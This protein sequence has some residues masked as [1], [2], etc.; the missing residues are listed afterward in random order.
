MRERNTYFLSVVGSMGRGKCHTH[1]FFQQQTPVAI[2]WGRVLA[3]NS[4]CGGQTM[5]R[6]VSETK[7]AYEAAA[8]RI[9]LSGVSPDVGL[10]PVHF[11]E[12]ATRKSGLFT[13]GFLWI[14]GVGGVFL[15]A[16][17]LATAVISVAVACFALFRPLGVLSL[18]LPVAWFANG[19]RREL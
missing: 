14:V 11:T 6:W 7:L 5:Q 13:A 19:S 12:S 1:D 9:F 18:L 8:A 15:A 4:A 3:T 2:S 16:T 17:G 10:Y